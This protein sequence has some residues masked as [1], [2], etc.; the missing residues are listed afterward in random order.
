MGRLPKLMFGTS[1]VPEISG[2]AAA[3]SDGLVEQ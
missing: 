1:N 2:G 3:W